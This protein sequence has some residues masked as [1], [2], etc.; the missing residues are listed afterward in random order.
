[1]STRLTHGGRRIDRSKPVTFSFNGKSLKGFQGDTLAS[2]LLAND[3]M[4]MGRSFKYHRPRGV[5][6]SG[7]EE[8]NALMNM[9]EGGKFEPNQRATTTEVFDG[10]AAKSQNHWPNLEFDIGVINNSFARF[11]PAGF[12]YK[13]FLFPRF[14]WKHIYE[15]FIRQSAGLGQAP[16]ARDADT[17]EHFYFFADVAVIGGGLAGLQ[18]AKTAALSGAKV[19][20]M[21]Q[22]PFWGGRAAVDGGELDGAPAGEYVSRLVAELEA[23]ENVTLRTRMMGAGVYDHGYLL[24]YERL[25]DHAPELEGPRHRLW[26]IRASQIITA[27][28]AIERPLSFAGND[29][30]GV[31]LAG[32]LR[33]YIAD[34]GV[35]AG[36]RVVVVTNN[37]DAYKTALAVKAAGLD[38]PVILDARA[39]GG[40]AA[41]DAA[42]AA[43]IRVENG[44][45][46]AK[47]TG[48]K[49][50][51]SVKICAQAGEGGVLEE[52]A[53]DAV[54]MSGGWSPVVHLW[55]H[56]G[57]KL[58]WDEEHAMFR[59]DETRPPLG[60]T[61][62]GFVIPAGA[63]NGVM[64]MGVGLAD[65]D[66]AGRK[67][68][69]ALGLTAKAVKFARF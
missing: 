33:D 53:C 45:A 46:I 13:T 4:M 51:K 11:L 60:A 49:R 19:L 1:M 16:K 3:Q 68:V 7:A 34:Y 22:D 58:V 9:G 26:K 27:S 41:A 57:G 65:A 56:C 61:G 42:R 64:D 35:S 23:M 37:D 31:M 52:I 21:E 59:P 69:E 47:V 40:G 43:G 24:G 18:A 38:V 15:P 6:A 63:A 28:G 29:I 32:A 25:R 14:A 54:A 30:P 50:V 12:Y 62:E 17:Y 55:S 67:A 5:V 8:P 44:K 39:G 20:L 36:D 48:G 10:L 66:H 2:A